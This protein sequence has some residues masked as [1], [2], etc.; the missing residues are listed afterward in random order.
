VL[1]A[2]MVAEKIWQERQIEKKI[3][4]A[5]DGAV[6]QAVHQYRLMLVDRFF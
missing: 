5:I 6:P 3:I 4:S 2:E 1:A